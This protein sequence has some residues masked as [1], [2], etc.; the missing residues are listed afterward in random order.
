MAS[1]ILNFGLSFQEPTIT[2]REFQAKMM[3]FGS[4][5]ITAQ[6]KTDRRG[7]CPGEAIALTGGF[8][9]FTS[10]ATRPITVSLFQKTVFTAK[11]KRHIHRV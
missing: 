10:S 9:N 2:E 6:I 5:S 3:C 4:G 11:G 1:E 8:C 7:Y